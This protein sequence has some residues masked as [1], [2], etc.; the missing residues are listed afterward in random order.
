MNVFWREQPLNKEETELYRLVLEAHHQS[1]FRGN[2]SGQAVVMA[3][4]GSKD[5]YKAIAAGLLT[6]GVM[7]G[8]IE[9]TVN[10]LSRVEDPP[11]YLVQD[12]LAMEARV[13]GWGNSFAKGVPDSLWVKVD[14]HLELYFHVVWA[15]MLTVTKA[16]HAAGKMIYPNPSAYTAAA[17]IVF[18]L[19]ASI[20]AYLLVVGRLGAWTQLAA[21]NLKE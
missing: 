17:A 10:F 19:P 20:A 14:H 7:H 5:Y 9:Q 21:D 16:L 6:L 3:A 4:A 11:K 18:E 15:K 8:P 13:P 2:I 12:Y 1:S